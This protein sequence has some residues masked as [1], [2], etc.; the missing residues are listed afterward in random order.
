MTPKRI[1]IVFIN[2]VKAREEDL[3]SKVLSLED[4]GPEFE[5]QN[6]MLGGGKVNPWS[7]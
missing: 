2:G 1:K 6:S 5:P 7:L 3:V 4:Q